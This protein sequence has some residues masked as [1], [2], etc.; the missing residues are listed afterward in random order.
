MSNEGKHIFAKGAE[1]KLFE[2]FLQEVQAGG[3]SAKLCHP[4]ACFIRSNEI[5][6]HVPNLAIICMIDC[7]HG[8]V[9]EHYVLGE[10]LLKGH[11]F[12]VHFIYELCITMSLYAVAKP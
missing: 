11:S 1:A 12:P 9:V 4:L 5:D 7:L 8:W 3:H 10:W 2:I 6:T